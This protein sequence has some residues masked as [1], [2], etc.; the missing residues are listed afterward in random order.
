MEKYKTHSLNG[1]DDV[2]I[3]KDPRTQ[4]DMTIPKPSVLVQIPHDDSLLQQQMASPPPALLTPTDGQQQLGGQL[5]SI[6]Q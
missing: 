6:G 4:Q 2:S 1:F 5:K 3:A